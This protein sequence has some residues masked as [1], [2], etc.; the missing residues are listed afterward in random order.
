MALRTADPK[1]EDPVEHLRDYF[2]RYRDP[3]W[4]VVEQLT[5]ENAK[6]KTEDIPSLQ[7]DLFFMEM[8]VKGLKLQN[9]ARDCYLYLDPERTVSKSKKY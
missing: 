7:D 9:Q 6:L 8:E 2:G 5:A 4:D 1:P 3:M